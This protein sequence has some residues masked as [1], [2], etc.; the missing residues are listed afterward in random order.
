M[1]SRRR[2]WPSKRVRGLWPRGASVAQRPQ[3]VHEVLLFLLRELDVETPVVEVDD[4]TERRGRAVGEVRC[5]C[6]Q[7]PQLLHDD[8]ADVSA[9]SGDECTS[10]VGG[11]DLATEERVRWS[12]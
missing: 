9:S 12:G 3:E 2:P 8:G 4:L 5:A 7:P 6:G 1:H 10:R 11:V